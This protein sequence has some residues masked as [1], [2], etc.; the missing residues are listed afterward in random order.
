MKVYI[1]YRSVYPLGIVQSCAANIEAQKKEVLKLGYSS[2]Y[3]EQAYFDSLCYRDTIMPE[4]MKAYLSGNYSFDKKEVVQLLYTII[5]YGRKR[6]QDVNNLE[7]LLKTVG[8][9]FVDALEIKQ[10][11]E[12]MKHKFRLN[13]LILRILKIFEEELFIHQRYVL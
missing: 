12:R 3:F 4:S 2:Q 1:N 6:D 8:D 11:I 7:A 13:P 5:Y 10:W 9:F